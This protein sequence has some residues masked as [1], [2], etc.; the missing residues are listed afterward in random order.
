MRN[1]HRTRISKIYIRTDKTK[2]SRFIKIIEIKTDDNIR[3]KRI[4]I[5]RK[6]MNKMSLST[7]ILNSVFFVG[8]S[9]P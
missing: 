9:S 4:K 5:H 3:T 1:I 6:G 2:Q 8:T 7:N